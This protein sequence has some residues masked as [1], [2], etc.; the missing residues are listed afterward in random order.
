[1]MFNSR[2]WAIRFW[3]IVAI[4]FVVHFAVSVSVFYYA[5]AWSLTWPDAV[6]YG[7]RSRVAD[8]ALSVISFPLSAIR[9]AFPDFRIEGY[10]GWIPFAMVSL[11][12]AYVIARLLAN[13][14]LARPV[15]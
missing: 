15:Q 4:V 11:L 14:L 9:A 10:L 1:M 12:W 3:H 13:R 2:K 8:V 6:P 5:M 7:V